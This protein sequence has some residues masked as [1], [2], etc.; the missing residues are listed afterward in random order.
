M[1]IEL[2]ANIRM[3]LLI[4]TAVLV[5]FELLN[6]TG[7]FG[8]GD[9]KLFLIDLLGIGSGDALRPDTGFSTQDLIGFI[10]AGIMGAIWF[11]S[12]EDDLDWEALLADD[13]E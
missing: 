9:N 1:D 4:S 12:K 10:L 6:M 8:G 11:L 5:V 7:M 3:A 2:D 13:E